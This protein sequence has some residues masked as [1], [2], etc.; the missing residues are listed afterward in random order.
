MDWEGHWVCE[1]QI[2]NILSEKNKVL[3]IEQTRTLLANFQKSGGDTSPLMKFKLIK[4][5]VR[6]INRNL[7][8]VSP[9]F[10]LPFRYLP[11]IY[12][13]NQKMRF[14][15]IGRLLK[16]LKIN[17]PIIITFDPD[18]AKII[19][20]IDKKLSIYYRNDN[21]EKRGLWFNPD[22]FVSKRETELMNNV[23]IVCA[24]SN[25]LAAKSNKLNFKTFVVPNGV[26]I[27][28]FTR[29][30]NKKKDEPKDISEIPH[31]RIG[32]VGILDWRTDIS[33]IKRLARMHRDWSIVLVGPVSNGNKENFD[34]CMSIDN[35]Y[36][37]GP[38]KVNEV[39]FYMKA[40]DVGLIPY[41]INEYTKNILSLKVFEYSAL[42]VPTVSTQMPQL[43]KYSEVIH[44]ANS[45]HEFEATISKCLKDNRNNRKQELLEFAR[46][47]TWRKRT[48]ELSEIIYRELDLI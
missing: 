2:A 40:L 6:R 43:E 14:Y 11:I 24:L 47:N 46:D 25:G 37:L 36:F 35:I 1:Q 4:E 18:S 29:A 15:W 39:P 41:I 21:H 31:P 19:N 48:E 13:I 45:A 20:K 30:L 12:Q 22:H 3:Y 34:R 28:L 16:K 23:N 26:N 33:L 27:N 38:K 9:P 17:F 5:G 7:F 42:G 44:L 10:I 32:V 8:V